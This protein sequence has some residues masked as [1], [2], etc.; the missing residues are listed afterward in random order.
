LFG[1]MDE[2]MDRWFDGYM[3]E[4]VDGWTDVGW[5]D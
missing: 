2:R 4:Y 3:D 5:V 1:W